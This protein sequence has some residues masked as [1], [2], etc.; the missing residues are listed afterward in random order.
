[1]DD[2]LYIESNLFYIIF[3]KTVS[4]IT[5]FF[6]LPI[7]VTAVALTVQHDKTIVLVAIRVKTNTTPTIIKTIKLLHLLFFHHLVT[8]WTHTL[9]SKHWIKVLNISIPLQLRDKRSLILFLL[10]FLPVHISKKTMLF[11]GLSTSHC[12]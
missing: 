8:Q 7:I 2:V 3:L 10:Q 4:K 1:L 11:D 9:L 6:D 12:P 5:L